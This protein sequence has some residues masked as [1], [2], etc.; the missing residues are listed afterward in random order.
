MFGN[1]LTSAIRASNRSLLVLSLI[2]GLIT[3]CT[4]P[5]IDTSS[6]TSTEASI[7]KVRSHLPEDAR[8]DFSRAILL[9]TQNQECFDNPVSEQ[10]SE[11]ESSLNPCSL[12]GKTG[13]QIIAEARRLELEQAGRERN[14]ALEEF[15]NLQVEQAVLDE[16]RKLAEFA[17]QQLVKFEVLDSQFYKREQQAGGDEPIIELTVFNGT[18]ELV[19]RA[20][21]EGR[22]TSRGRYLPWVSG[23]FNY[24][25]PGGIDPGETATWIL[26]PGKFS[27]WGRINAPENSTLSVGVRRLDGAN[28]ESLFETDIY[29][30]Y[31]M[32]R[33]GQVNKRMQQLGEIYGFE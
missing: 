9:L 18:D 25:I 1:Y 33:H 10:I 29:S 4:E 6:E 17:W 14:I 31:E 23:K 8:A 7:D 3:G 11:T 12:G 16:Q 5:I 2:L 28:G 21:F 19:S 26:A 24:Q 27:D 30:A 20:Y 32:E 13:L 22:L 15:Q